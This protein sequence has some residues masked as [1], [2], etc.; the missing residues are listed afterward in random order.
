[1]P[2]EAFNTARRRSGRP[3]IARVRGELVEWNDE[4]LVGQIGSTLG[5]AVSAVIKRHPL[6]AFFVLAFALTWAPTPFGIFMAAG[7]LVA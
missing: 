7:P 1:M 3:S 4:A 6:V 5:F 2:R